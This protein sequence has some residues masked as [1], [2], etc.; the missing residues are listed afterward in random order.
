MKSNDRITV[1]ILGLLA[2]EPLSGYGLKKRMEVSVS[3]FVSPSFGNIYPTLKK[4][5][6][7]GAIEEVPSETPRK[8]RVYQTTKKGLQTLKAWLMSSIPE[9]EPFLL[10]EYF[11]EFIDRKVRIKLVAS[12]ITHLQA[13]VKRYEAIKD[14]YQDV[15][16]PF[17]YQTLRYGFSQAKHDLAWYETLLKEL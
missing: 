15:M 2:Q 8:K 6:A 4:L 16:G 12:Y 17:P 5:E 11:F 9:H 3:N 14:A 13:R 1:I 7:S 10:R